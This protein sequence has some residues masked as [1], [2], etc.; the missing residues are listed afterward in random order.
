MDI[1]DWIATHANRT[2]TAL[3]QID[4]ATNRHFTYAE[5]HERVARIGGY[6]R[7][8]AKVSIGDVVA[9]LG[10]NSSE[11]L[12][13]DFACA[14]IGAIF[15]PLNTRLTPIEIAFQL[16]DAHPKALFV[17]PGYEAVA[18]DAIA[19]SDV[20]IQLLSFG[21]ADGNICLKDISTTGTPLFEVEPR[22]PEDGWTL[23]YSSGTTG[24]PKGVLHSH[25]GVL[26]QAIG[27]CVPLGLNPQSRG[28]TVLPYFHISG[29]NIFAH[30]MFYAGGCQLTMER[31]DPAEMLRVL[32]N[33]EF[34]ITH[35]CGVPT[36]FEM[37]AQRP[38]FLTSDLNSVEGA[39][40]GGAPSTEA[41]LKTYTAKNMPLIQGYGLT[42][43]GP[44]VTVLDA[45]DA[46]K[47]LG[48]AGK[49][50]MHV[51]VK[52]ARDDGA[53][54]SAGEEG[55]IIIRGPSVIT[56]YF[57]RPDAQRTDFIDG[58][59]KTGDIGRFDDDG[60][61]FIVDRKKDMFISGGENVYPA[62]VE[63]C[64]AEI[65]GVAQV[66][67]IGVPDEKWGEVGVACIVK[68]PDADLDKEGIIALCEGKLARY[69]LPK[70]VRFFD[71]L[72]MGGSGK[73]LKSKLREFFSL[74]VNSVY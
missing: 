59:L 20:D 39:F 12:D 6:L 27:N 46:V 38:E 3:A 72:P 25:A 18:K 32:S 67:V 74:N 15:L 33:P 50:I 49:P 40:V 21:G 14:R 66:A 57:R 43:S 63:N 55:E 69:K 29:L 26:M 8:E 68:R 44:T 73:V 56:E 30:A 70:H 5:M 10:D 19:A 24:R 65:E 45:A 28:L 11:T 9:V 52:V 64:I 42:E 13:V 58:W 48:S 4:H 61:L 36:M 16:S 71:A 35:F 34:A 7:N 47:K 37:M 54:A 53:E 31:F 1:R 41:L 62:E 17:G 2:P 51:D 60:F 22:A 23:I